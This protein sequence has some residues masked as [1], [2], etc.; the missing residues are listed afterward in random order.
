MKI[1]IFYCNKII[2]Q[3]YLVKLYKIIGNNLIFICNVCYNDGVWEAAIFAFGTR[4][5]IRMQCG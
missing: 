5:A 2:I 4:K 3:F 1:N